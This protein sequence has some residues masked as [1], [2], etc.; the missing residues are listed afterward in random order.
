M[1]YTQEELNASKAARREK[2]RRRRDAMQPQQESPTPLPAR[3]YRG[4]LPIDPSR[5]KIRVQQSSS[6][7]PEVFGDARIRRAKLRARKRRFVT[8]EERR[9]A[10]TKA[11]RAMR[12][13]EQAQGLDNYETLMLENKIKQNQ[14]AV[15]EIVADAEKLRRNPLS[16]IVR[17]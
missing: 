14:R 16:V 11:R 5:R 15:D 2:R 9:I 3:S 6:E 1:N 4:R 10:R 7:E 12:R 8:P 17:S 13:Q